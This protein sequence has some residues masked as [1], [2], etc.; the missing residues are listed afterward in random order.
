MAGENELVAFEDFTGLANRSQPTQGPV[1]GRILNL[2][3]WL[4]VAC[5]LLYNILSQKHIG[6]HTIHPDKKIQYVLIINSTKRNRNRLIKNEY[7]QEFYITFHH[8]YYS[9]LPC[10]SSK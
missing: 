2:S 3:H 6:L 1:P 10:C 4:T 5:L 9:H 7:T 8:D